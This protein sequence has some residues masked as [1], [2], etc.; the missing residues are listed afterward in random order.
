[1]GAIVSLG[2]MAS[3]PFDTWLRLIIWLIVG[4]VIFFTYSRKHSRLNDLEKPKPQA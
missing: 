1:M 4:L 3:L 2:L